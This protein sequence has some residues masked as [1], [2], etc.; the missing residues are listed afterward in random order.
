MREILKKYIIPLVIV[1][2]GIILFVVWRLNGSELKDSWLY[3]ISFVIVIFSSI[4][5]YRK[6]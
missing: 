5:I 1:I 3:I 2:T 4:D 6:Q